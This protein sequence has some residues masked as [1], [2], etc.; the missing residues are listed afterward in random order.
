MVFSSPVFL[1][2]FLPL[3]LLLTC[4]GGSLRTKNT[5]LLLASLLFY[6]WGEG[7]YTLL[8]L[9]VILFD[10]VVGVTLERTKSPSAVLAVAVVLNLGTLAWFKYANLFADALAPAFIALGLDPPALDMI[11]LPIGISFYIFHSLSYVIDVYRGNAKAQSSLGITALYITLFP[12]LVAGPIIRYHDVATQFTQRV[13]NVEGVSAGLRRFVVG[14]AKK[15]LVADLCARIADPVFALPTEQL[16]PAVAWLGLVAYAVQIYFDFSGYSDMAIGLGRVFGFHFLE[17]FNRPYAATSLRDF[18]KRWH[19]SLT[20]FFREY[21]YFPLGGNRGGTVRTYANL[22]IVFLLTGLWH[23]AN[24]TFVVWGCIHGAFMVIERVGFG[25]VLD[26]APRLFGR[27]YTL[28]VVLVA[29]VFFRADTIVGG[30]EYLCCL[31]TPGHGDPTLIYPAYYLPNDV[32][33]ASLVGVIGGLG[34]ADPLLRWAR[35]RV[36][37][38]SLTTWPAYAWDLATV[39][40]FV[41]I[42][43]N[44]ATRTYDPFIY[45]RF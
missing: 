2:L 19:I 29:W 35:E 1:F 36:H 33:I 9:A 45:F 39:G 26:R 18:W 32:L 31:W 13:L 4:A 20:N 16:T 6:W 5:V 28:L 30:W 22:I 15:V 43:M 27:I 3:V 12:Q 14:L 25:A 8:M 37:G 34:I 44:V 24:W 17:N 41:L 21:L 40:L 23:G 42:A 38:H 7:A 10:H 11:H